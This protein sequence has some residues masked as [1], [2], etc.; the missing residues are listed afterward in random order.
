MDIKVSKDGR[1]YIKNTD[2]NKWERYD[3]FL[4]KKTYGDIPKGY[5]IKSKNGDINDYSINNLKLVFCWWNLPEIEKKCELCGNTFK[6]RNK[7]ARFCDFNCYRTD[8]KINAT[9]I[10][11][12]EKCGKEFIHGGT[13]RKFCSKK[14]NVDYNRRHN[15]LP[16]A[17]FKKGD[18]PW[19]KGTTGLMPTPK[20]KLEIGAFSIRRTGRKKLQFRFIKNEEGKWI[21]NDRYV[22]E[23]KYGPIPK[24]HKMIHKDGDQLN[25]NLDNL[26]TIS[27]RDMFIKIL[28]NDRN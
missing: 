21:R 28:N 6:T 1:K 24:S 2:S 20:N 4:W 9:K 16:K 15:I 11:K 18:D 3:R 19:N 8:R 5:T 7:D 12:N 14:C 27:A 10:C 25:D 13:N 22:L 26:D 23:Q 17:S